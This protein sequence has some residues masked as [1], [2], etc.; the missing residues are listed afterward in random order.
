[1]IPP[2]DN[3]GKNVIC[4]YILTEMSKKIKIFFGTQ[5]IFFRC[6]DKSGLPVL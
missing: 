1:M 2:S 6:L 5:K 4:I 3:M